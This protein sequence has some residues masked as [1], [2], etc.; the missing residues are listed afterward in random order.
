MAMTRRD[1][2]VAEGTFVACAVVTGETNK[3]L[4]K[5]AAIGHRRDFMN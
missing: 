5:I 2:F 1:C 4:M 3:K